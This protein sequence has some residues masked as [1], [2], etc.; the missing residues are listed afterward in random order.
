MSETAT[1]LLSCCGAARRLDG[2]EPEGIVRKCRSL[3]LQ[4]YRVGTYGGGRGPPAVSH[5]HQSPQ[6]QPQLSYSPGLCWDV[7]G[8]K[9]CSFQWLAWAS[10][11]LPPNLMGSSSQEVLK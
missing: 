3:L 7:A 6:A 10:R 9:G 4:I 5:S 2:A 1:P 11:S 8:G